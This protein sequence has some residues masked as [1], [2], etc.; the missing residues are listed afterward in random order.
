MEA[1]WEKVTGTKFRLSQYKDRDSKAS[2]TALH[3]STNKVALYP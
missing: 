3:K 1:A 2:I